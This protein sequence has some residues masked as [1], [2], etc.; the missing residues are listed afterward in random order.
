MPLID[1]REEWV[2]SVAESL[3]EVAGMDAT[4]PCRST[5]EERLRK[6]SVFDDLSWSFAKLLLGTHT[7]VEAIEQANVLYKIGSELL[8]DSQLSPFDRTNIQAVIDQVTSFLN[9]H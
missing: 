1:S 4:E 9:S 6:M 8:K 5:F 3:L 2:D 7:D